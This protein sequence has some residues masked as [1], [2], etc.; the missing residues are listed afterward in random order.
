MKK[1]LILLLFFIVSCSGSDDENFT[2]NTPEQDAKN[3]TRPS[4]KKS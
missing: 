1:G 3:I 4:L 2:N